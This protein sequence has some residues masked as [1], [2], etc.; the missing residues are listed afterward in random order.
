VVRVPGSPAL[1]LQQ[2]LYPTFRIS[3]RHLSHCIREDGCGQQQ[4]GPVSGSMPAVEYLEGSEQTGFVP[5][6]MCL[7]T[8]Q[9]AQTVHHARGAVLHHFLTQRAALE[10]E[11]GPSVCGMGLPSTS[12]YPV[13]SASHTSRLPA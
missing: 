12:R 11:L 7:T 6:R 9:E 4:I 5:V 1:F 3:L 2:E 10:K 13:G 8:V